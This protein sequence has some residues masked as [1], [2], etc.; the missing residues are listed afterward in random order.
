MVL[1][2]LSCSLLQYKVKI[3]LQFFCDKIYTRTR[4]VYHGI[5]SIHIQF[6][7]LKYLRQIIYIDNEREW[8]KDTCGTP[9]VAAPLDEHYEVTWAL[10]S[11]EVIDP[12]SDPVSGYQ[13][14]DE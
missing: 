8:L 3:S 13:L 2:T 5:I 7:V 11:N 10:I 6:T 14:D 4:A 12:S 1:P 9:H